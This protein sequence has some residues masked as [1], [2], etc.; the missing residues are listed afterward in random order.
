MS[1]E[2]IADDVFEFLAQ[3]IDSVPQLEALLLLWEEPTRAWSAPELAAR[4]YVEASVA[5]H[6]LA[7]L[8]RRQLAR[9]LPGP[10]PRWAYDHAWDPSGKR[11][12][13]VALA[14][15]RHVV[16]IATFIHAGASQAVREFARAFDLKKER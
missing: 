4:I 14:Y 16:R 13:Q 3:R 15:R 9:E 5:A 10:E 11:I 2:E 1:R 7:S 6:V 12:A 8:Q